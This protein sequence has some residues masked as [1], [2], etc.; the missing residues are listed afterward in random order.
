MWTEEKL[1]MAAREYVFKETGILDDSVINAFIAGCKYIINNT[2]KEN[3]S[4]S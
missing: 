4:V 1:E 3:E 2:Q